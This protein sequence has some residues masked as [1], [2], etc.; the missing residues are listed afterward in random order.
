MYHKQLLRR[1]LARMFALLAVCITVAFLGTPLFPGPGLPLLSS[2]TALAQGSAT[3]M[4]TAG[5]LHTVGLESDGT[6]VAVGDNEYGRCN[7]SS[8]TGI[9]QVAAGW[10]H[11]VGLKSDG[12]V[13][14]VG[15][16]SYGQCNVSSWTGITQVAAGGHN[17]VGLKSD[18][19]VL[20][21]GYNEYGQCNVSSWTGITQ[22]AAGGHNTMGLKSDGT[23]VAVGDNS[24]GQCN[25]SSWTGITQVASGW[26]HTVGLKSDGTVVAVGCTPTPE[27][28]VSSWTGITQVAEGQFHT[29]GLKSDGTVVAMG[30]DY[31]GQS[32]GVS[33]WTGITQVAAGW[34]HNM[35]IKSD[36]TVVAVGYNY[37]G[38][39]NVSD[40][41]LETPPPTPA[42]TP[43]PMP[44]PTPTPSPTPPPLG[45]TLHLSI[46][47]T[48][49]IGFPLP[50]NTRILNLQPGDEVIQFT[51]PN[52]IAGTNPMGVL[53]T[54][55]FSP[56]NNVS[57]DLRGTMYGEGQPMT[58]N[59]DGLGGS[60]GCT[61]AKPRFD[62]AAGNTFNA[63]YV[64]NLDAI[65]SQ[66]HRTGY[67]V[68]TSGTG[69]FSGQVL[70]GTMSDTTT[71]DPVT[72][73]ITST[74]TLTLRRY[75]GSE[76]SGPNAISGTGTDTSGNA[77]SFGSSE[78]PNPDDEFIQFS[79]SNIVIAKDDPALYVVGGSASSSVTGALAG[80]MTQT[81][82][83]IYIP[84]TPSSQGLTIGKFTVSNASGTVNGVFV[85]D[86]LESSGAGSG[87]GNA[88]M[89]AL[90]E[91]ATGAYAG[92]DF[93]GN[94]TYTETS[95]A[96]TFNGNL[97]VL[98]P[99]TANQ[100]PD[101]PSN[102]SPANGATAISV[103][104]T[105]HSSAFA[106]PD[107]GDTHGASQWQ[108]STNSG[109]YSS[110]VYDSSTDASHLTSITIPSST[111][112]YSTTYYWHVKHQDNH[113]EW[114]NWSTETSFTTQSPPV[115]VE[116]AAGGNVTVS[117]PSAVMT[118]DTITGAG[119]TTVTTTSENPVGPTPSGFNVAGLF[120][121]I[122]TTAIYTGNVTVGI[123]Y[124][125]STPNP[126]NLR[127]F[128]YEGGQWRDVTTWVD[129]SNH[130]IYGEVSS[131][132]WF[133]IG[134]QWVYVPSAG[135]PVFP[136]VYIGIA[137]ALGAGV[138]AY[139]VRR[140][141]V[142]Q[143]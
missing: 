91:N 66:A 83:T 52:L 101:Q 9:T 67:M 141:L 123:S 96:F 102:V 7:V 128:H 132:S 48:V 117:A 77:R 64:A 125:P 11:T 61:V 42:P 76:I 79:R 140:R 118:F 109:S 133:F 135:V 139:Y 122:T 107:T 113:G 124:D 129:T 28:D 31:Y 12:T 65:A 71:W 17:T 92:K 114:S 59:W 108:V 121:D 44:T 70:I 116:T 95:G 22:V 19:T 39:C 26:G 111:L 81:Y 49:H 68:S 13:V 43:T 97:Y 56:T 137:A 53:V 14:A 33:S 36:G 80:T 37:Y 41:N 23:V 25:V 73:N 84:G 16:N 104:P 4:V 24:C 38:Q 110:P 1:W 90:R 51:R 138:L 103:M 60:K 85:C 120:V 86:L 35:G 20:A 82:N 94:G 131:L 74:A 3:P 57:G 115:Q 87:S 21:V 142:R 89:F 63:V 27:F 30:S 105:L 62:D 2:G 112:N 46:S 93:Y 40:W 5:E 136:S 119:N 72:G 58:L 8:W 78:G 99:S 134:G 69:N 130:I 100:P 50:W 127:L 98:E 143:G 47:S 54:T 88:F 75:S 18:G 126:Q 10:L 15:D 29:V 106:D 32:S 55:I 34:G 45:E 6:V